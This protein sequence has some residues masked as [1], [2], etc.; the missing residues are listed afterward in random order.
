MVYYSLIYFPGEGRFFFCTLGFMTSLS[1]NSKQRTISGSRLTSSRNLVLSSGEYRQTCRPRSCLSILFA[2]QV[3]SRV[4][5]LTSR[6]W[7]CSTAPT[8]LYSLWDWLVVWD[9]CTDSLIF[10]ITYY[11]DSP[12]FLRRRS[13]VTSLPLIRSFRSLIW[14]NDVGCSAV[15]S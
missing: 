1:W 11:E 8:L 6:W 4:A 12:D 14:W 5:L 15:Y 9:G 13:R 2:V 10:R 7:S 3:F